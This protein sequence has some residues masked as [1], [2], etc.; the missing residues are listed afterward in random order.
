[1]YRGEHRDIDESGVKY[2]MSVEEACRFYREDCCENVGAFIVEGGM[3]VAGVILPPAQYIPRSVQAVRNAGGIYIADEVQTGFGRL[4]SCFWAFQHRHSTDDEIV[5]PDIVTMG[6]PF[7]NGM[8]LAAVVTTRAISDAF[9]GMG[10]EYFNTFGGNPVCAAAGLAM[11]DVLESEALQENA[12]KVGQYLK[13]KFLHLGKSLNIIGDIRGSGLFIGIELV[14]DRI[15]KEPAEAETSYLCTVMKE[16]YSI[17][18]SIDGLY[19]NVLVVKPPMVFSVEDADE[20]VK[21]FENAIRVD[22]QALENISSISK[23]PT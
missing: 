5:I 13:D 22:L 7:G 2:S 23:T 20:F 6:K 17:L 10:V 18:T 12:A 15:T 19:N 11:L 14:R 4:G 3:S 8:P 9:E 16:K 1:V 21:G